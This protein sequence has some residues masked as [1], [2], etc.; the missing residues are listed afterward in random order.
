M[1]NIIER[2]K[3][4]FELSDIKNKNPNSDFKL[5]RLHLILASLAL[6]VLAL[7]MP[8]FVMQVYDRIIAN[9]SIGTMNVLVIGVVTV[10]IFDA[11]IKISRNYI[12]NWAGMV[13][14]YVLSSNAMRYFI[15]SDIVRMERKGPGE[16]LQAVNSFTKLKSYYSGQALIILADIPFVILFLVLIA[17]LTG[18]LVIVPITVIALFIYIA[19]KHGDDLNRS[20]KDKDLHENIRYNFIVETLSGVHTVKAYGLESVFQR[21]YEKLESESS[22][23]SYNLSLLNSKSNNITTF[24]SQLMTISIVGFGAPLVIQGDYTSGTLIGCVMI[25][26]RLMQPV[27]KGLQLWSKMQDFIIASEKARKIFNIPQLRRKKQYNKNARAGKVEVENLSFSYGKQRILNNINLQLFPGEIIAINGFHNAGKTTLLKLIAGI[28]G[29]NKG[30]V[31][32]DGVNVID[33]LADELIC[34]VG[35]MSEEGIIFKGTIMDNITGFDESKELKAKEIAILLDIH[36]EISMLPNGYE[37]MLND[38]IA[39]PIPPGLRQRIAMARVL[40]N[41]PRLIIFDNASRGLDRAG[42]NSVIRLLGL[43]KGK[44]T[45][46]IVSSDLNIRRLVDRE[47]ALEDGELK[48]IDIIDSKKYRVQPYSEL[49]I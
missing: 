26:G 32:V 48:P 37:T 17:L 29:P 14:E 33:Y 41:K 9:N 7:A 28:Y 21:R 1:L 16:L 47:F 39:D 23:A 24:F 3:L 38:G 2:S 18:P 27:Q 25:S 8:I 45:M 35:Y 10:V 22:L 30:K 13:Y 6:N 44:A 34:H 20:I 43:L 11:I 46:I 5:K 40:V 36:K 12:S 49:R 42:Y 4:L 15:N 19:K 31:K